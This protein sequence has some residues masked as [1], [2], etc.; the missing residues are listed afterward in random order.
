MNKAAPRQP[1]STNAA[2]LF[3]PE[4]LPVGRAEVEL[5]DPPA[6]I[7][8][9]NGLIDAS[10][11]MVLIRLHTR[12]IGV[13]VLDGTLGRRWSTHLPTVLEE[14]GSAIEIHLIEDGLPD[15][16]AASVAALGAET[17]SCL[18]VREEVLDAPPL[19]SVVVAT[20]ERPETLRDCLNSLLG[21]RYPR[22][23]FEIIVVDNAPET[24]ITSE[25]IARE[26]LGQVR[27]LREDRRGL[28]SAHNRG[29]DVA[30]GEI[31]AFVDDDVIVDR[32]WLAAIAEGF[33]T[34]DAVGAVTGLILPAELETPAQLL[35][36]QHGGFGKGFDT[37][38]FDMDQNRPA[39]PL[40]PFTAGKLGSGANMAFRTA[41]LRSFGGFD[42]AI[43]TGT[44]A[45]GGDDLAALFRVVIGHRVVYEPAAI[46]WHRH[47]R[48]LTA[49]RNQAYGYGVGLGA[50]LT[51][52]LVHEPRMWIELLRRLPAGLRYEFDSGSGRNQ[53][54]YDGWPSDFS[55]LERRGLLSGPMAYAVSRWRT[56][57]AVHEDQNPCPR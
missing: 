18:L 14:L 19:I 29:L 54:R 5:S 17:P 57:R 44:H 40:F 11:I 55:T 34:H 2:R 43:G 36:E 12:P 48:D 7:E 41:L 32:H 25:M 56:C 37:R 51:S 30:R 4:D 46:V 9:T 39:D 1:Q 47:H 38:V 6:R 21:M 31:I 10:K 16:A 15:L 22:H 33:A 50:Y 27:Y 42:C 26:F 49:L 13:V 20:R 35:L 28:S 24:D 45:K 3:T 52:V 23:A 53:G 8:L